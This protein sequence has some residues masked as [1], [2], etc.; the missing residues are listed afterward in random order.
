MT[1]ILLVYVAKNGDIEVV[2]CTEARLFES[3]K[4]YEH[5]ATLNAAS[6]IKNTL[7]ENPEIF[8]NLSC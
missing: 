4:D 3:N 1:A 8:K 2:D 6:W 7:I 5:I